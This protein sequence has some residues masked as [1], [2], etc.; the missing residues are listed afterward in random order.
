MTINEH[1]FDNREAMLDSLYELICEDLGRQL[2]DRENASLLLSGGSTP[3]PLYR[4]LSRAELDWERVQI[5]LVDERWVAPDNLAS[6]ERLLR[7]TMLINNAAEAQFLGMKNAAATPFDGAMECNLRYTDLPMPHGVC[8]LG[9]GPDGH[10]ASLFPGAEGLSQALESHQHCAPIRA[11][12][13]GVTGD[14]VE[15]MSLTPWSIRQSERLVLLITGEDKWEVFEQ[16]RANPGNDA[17]PISHFV[18]QQAPALEV[19][20]AP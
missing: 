16:A 9:M 1:R 13:S 12:R 15:R 17:L 8:L 11:I 19:Y 3:A 5:A 20:W 14:L 2:Q 10:T 6:N 4:R 18:A 7:E